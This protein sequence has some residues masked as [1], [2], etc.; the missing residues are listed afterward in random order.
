MN[1]GVEKTTVESGM[2]FSVSKS[3]SVAKSFMQRGGW[4]VDVIDGIN[5]D[6]ETGAAKKLV[7]I[8]KKS[9]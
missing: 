7:S 5:I 8:I 6:A 4:F 1:D 9:T 2:W 3:K